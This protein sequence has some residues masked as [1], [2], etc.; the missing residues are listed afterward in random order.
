MEVHLE[1]V[2]AEEME[3]IEMAMAAQAGSG[4]AR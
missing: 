3:A 2:D 1:E 4:G